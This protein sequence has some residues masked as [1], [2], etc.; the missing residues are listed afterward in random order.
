MCR[1]QVIYYE[2]AQHQHHYEHDDDHGWGGYWSRS[3]NEGPVKTKVLSVN[4][5]DKWAQYLVVA[6]I[7]VLFWINVAFLY[8]FHLVLSFG[9]NCLLL[10]PGGRNI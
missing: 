7:F 2:H 6:L 10:F 3:F 8:Y 1:L 5:R 4:T 9:L